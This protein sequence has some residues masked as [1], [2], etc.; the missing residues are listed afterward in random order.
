ME[1][2]RRHHGGIT[3]MLSSSW[4]VVRFL[5]LRYPHGIGSREF[6]R[7]FYCFSTAVKGITLMYLP[8]KFLRGYGVLWKLRNSCISRYLANVIVELVYYN[9]N[10][11]RVR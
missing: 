9:V 8:L 4:G 11:V 7:E 1:V 6:L 3:M 2:P 5:N 10:M